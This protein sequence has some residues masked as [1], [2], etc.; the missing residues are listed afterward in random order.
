LYCS[1]DELEALLVSVGPRSW[2]VE[3]VFRLLARGSETLHAHSTMLEYAN[4][5]GFS[6]SDAEW[7]DQLEEMS[8]T[9]AW[10]STT[11]VDLALFQRMLD[12]PEGPA[13]QDDDGLREIC[14]DLRKSGE[15]A[16]DKEAEAA[17]ESAEEADDKEAESAEESAEEEEEE[18]EEYDDE[19]EEEEEEEAGYSHEE[20]E[21]EDAVERKH[22]ILTCFRALAQDG[23]GT[24][25]NRDL[26]RMAEILDFDGEEEDWADVFEE[27]CEEFGWE[28]DRGITAEQFAEFCNSEESS[29]GYTTNEDL[30]EVL[31]K[32]GV[33]SP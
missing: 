33:S 9:Y 21:E 30:Q 6:G 24:M 23:Q 29:M 16:D 8:S 3:H 5:C 17:E 12:D 32:L 13:W 14:Q 31:D 19:E 1:D 26:M 25:T 20:E 7:N 4:F 18:E 2:L 11:G 10:D 28:A 27:L 22:L 15:E